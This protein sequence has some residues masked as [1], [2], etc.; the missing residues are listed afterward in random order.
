M[1]LVKFMSSN[2]GI[3]TPKKINQE[4][5]SKVASMVADETNKFRTHVKK[6]ETNTSPRADRIPAIPILS[7][8]IH[9]ANT[10]FLSEIMWTDRMQRAVG[11]QYNSNSD[12]K[13]RAL[14]KV[15]RI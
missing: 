5:N 13:T 11:A 2:P 12:M 6:K 3:D 9:V 7:S 8:T 4:L 1:L 10:I 15:H 14:T